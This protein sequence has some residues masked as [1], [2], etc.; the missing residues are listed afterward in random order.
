[1][2]SIDNAGGIGL[3][4]AGGDYNDFESELMDSKIYGEHRENKD[5]PDDGSYCFR[6]D[7]I[8]LYSSVAIRGGAIPIHPPTK[9]DYPNIA[10][11]DEG[12]WSGKAY[13]SDLEFRGFYASTAYGARSRAIML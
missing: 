13:F 5:C 4:V 6:Y 9:M 2:T 1:M 10:H 11:G 3:G 7:K 12:A 8:G